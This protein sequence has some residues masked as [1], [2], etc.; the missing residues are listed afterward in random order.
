MTAT[1]LYDATRGIWKVGLRKG[2]TTALSSE[3]TYALDSALTYA[4]LSALA[5]KRGS[6]EEAAQYLSKASALC[7]KLEWRECSGETIA[8]VA[9]R[10]DKHGLVGSGGQNP[11]AYV[12]HHIR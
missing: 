6:A 11:S 12:T 4:R 10:L 5:Q 8:A 3:K 9:K 7:S 2:K 1:E